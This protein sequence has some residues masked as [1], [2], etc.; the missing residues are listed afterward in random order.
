M[1]NHHTSAVTTQRILYNEEKKQNARYFN[2]GVISRSLSERPN[3]LKVHQ[4]LDVWLSDI[5]VVV[6]SFAQKDL[7]AFR[8]ADKNARRVTNKSL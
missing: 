7:S 4:W 1:C 8:Q 6:V 3:V 5:H 2:K